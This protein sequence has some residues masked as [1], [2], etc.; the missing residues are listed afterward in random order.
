MNERRGRG[1]RTERN[2]VV[3]LIIF[4]A[5][6][7]GLFVLRLVSLQIMNGKEY[8]E[9]ASSTYTYRFDITAARGDV[10][11]RYGRSLATNTAGY[12]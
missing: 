1:P 8:L 2:R 4:C 3:L 5:I 10:V 7:M 9:K 6:V 11:D 12:K